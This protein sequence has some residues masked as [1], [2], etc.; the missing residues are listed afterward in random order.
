MQNVG[1]INGDGFEDFLIR[2]SGF[3]SP[4]S[5]RLLYGPVNLKGVESAE[6]RAD[7]MLQTTEKIGNTTITII[8][9]R[10]EV[11]LQQLWTQTLSLGDKSSLNL[12]FD[13]FKRAAFASQLLHY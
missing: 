3:F 12:T 6:A 11:P 1:D 7:V 4:G 8:E 9:G 10:V 5:M 13:P 2:G